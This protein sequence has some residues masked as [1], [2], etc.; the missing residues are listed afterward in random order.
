LASS[1]DFLLL[2]ATGS[3]PDTVRAARAPDVP[4]IPQQAQLARQVSHVRRYQAVEEIPRLSAT[5]RFTKP[6]SI[7]SIET[8]QELIKNFR[9][10]VLINLCSPWFHRGR[11]GKVQTRGDLRK[12][13]VLAPMLA[14]ESKNK[15][16]TLF[17]NGA[18]NSREN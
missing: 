7:I 4:Q 16:P 2:G 12:Q 5:R 15:T 1:N 11:H 3:V 8:V 13:F 14:N 17:K 6:Y 9:L 18:N 10:I